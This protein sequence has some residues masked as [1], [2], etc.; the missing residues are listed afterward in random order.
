MW[1]IEK[2]RDVAHDYAV[3]LSTKTLREQ[4]CKTLLRAGN[5]DDELTQEFLIGLASGHPQ[6]P[7]KFGEGVTHVTVE[8][9]SYGTRCFVLHRIDGT[10]TDFSYKK[11]LTPPEPRE[12]VVSACRR[13]VQGQIDLFKSRRLHGRHPNCDITGV[14]VFADTAH[15]H[16]APPMFDT[17]VNQW[18][19]TA[20][21][22]EAVATRIEHADGQHG[23]RMCSA[24]LD[25]WGEWHRDNANLQLVHADVN[26]G[27]E[28]LRR[29]VSGSAPEGG[30]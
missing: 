19:T 6:A 4:V 26:L 18:V 27:V 22:Y 3:L 28:A 29:R 2:A 11:A 1:T 7:A 16:H 30:R 23:S 8:V 14:P 9:A 17:L 24:D 15:V 25:S 13:A 20:G 5:V 12:E 10:R 21:G